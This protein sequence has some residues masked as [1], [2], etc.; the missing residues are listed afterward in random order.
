MTMIQKYAVVAGLAIAVWV[1]VKVSAQSPASTGPAIRADVLRCMTLRR[2]GDP[3]TQA[4]YQALSRSGDPLLAAEGS[5]GLKDYNG[6]ND[7]FRAAVKR[8]PNDANVLVRWGR[9]Y[10]EHWQPGD[11]QDLFG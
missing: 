11:A 10:L 3:G 9:M 6:A 5:W 2:H 1:G 8:Y 7:S 4:C